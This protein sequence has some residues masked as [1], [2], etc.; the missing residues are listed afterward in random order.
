MK[1]LGLFPW[2]AGPCAN[3]PFKTL[4]DNS[5]LL[6]FLCAYRNL[7]NE[8]KKDVIKCAPCSLD[9]IDCYTAIATGLLASEGNA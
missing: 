9:A 3:D 2:I 1:S 4:W 6:C 8:V 7:S 5:A